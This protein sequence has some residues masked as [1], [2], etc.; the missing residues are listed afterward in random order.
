MAYQGDVLPVGLELGSILLAVI[1]NHGSSNRP[2]NAVVPRRL[3]NGEPVLQAAE[4]ALVRPPGQR[5]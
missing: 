3:E 2:G 5:I 1:I 4:D